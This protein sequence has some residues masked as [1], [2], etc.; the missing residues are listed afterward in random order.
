M[1]ESVGGEMKNIREVLNSFSK[2][3]LIELII[4]YSDN[5]YFDLDLFLMRA[6]EASLAEDIE[7]S[8]NGFYV[9]AQEYTGDADD[10]GADYLRDGAELCFE[11]AKKLPKV[12]DVKVLCNEIVADLTAAAEQDG[13]GMNT[14]SEWV[15]LE[16]RD[17]IQDYIEKNNLQF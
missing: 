7:N 10:R 3:E 8:W 12:E 13:I 15:Y 14:D 4:E 2:E 5:G 11:Q 16:V 17:K 9:K 6:D 1:K